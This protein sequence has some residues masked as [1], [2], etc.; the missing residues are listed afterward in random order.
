MIYFDGIFRLMPNGYIS[1][2]FH[3][4]SNEEMSSVDLSPGHFA[5][6][7]SKAIEFISYYLAWSYM[8]AA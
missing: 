6:M 5:Y 8:L 3:S 7:S 1:I 4:L 2:L